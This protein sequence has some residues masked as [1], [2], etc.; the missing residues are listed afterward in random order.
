MN[1]KRLYR[2]LIGLL[3]A[4]SLVACV[5][6]EFPAPIIEDV[7]PNYE[8]VFPQ[9]QVNQI[10]LVIAPNDWEAMQTN[11]V[12]IFGEAG[13]GGPGGRGPGDGG[14][15][16]GGPG[17]GGPDGG[18]PG[19]GGPRA[20]GPP[21]CPP[22]GGPGGPGGPGG[23]PGGPGGGPDNFS[24]ENPMWVPATLKFEDNEWENVGVR[25]KGNSSLRSGWREGNAKMPLKLDFDEFEDEYPEID[26]QRF[27]GFK[28]FSLANGFADPSFLRDAMTYDILDEA[29]LTAAETA[30]YEVMLDYGEGLVRLGLYTFIEVIDDTAVERHFGSDQGNIYEGDGRGANLA[31]GAFEQ[32][33]TSFHKENN[34]NDADWSDVE[35]LYEVLHAAQRLEDPAA[36]RA[37]L[38]A[39]FNTEVFLE[40]LALSAAIQHWDGYGSIPHNFYLYNDSESGQLT[41]ISWDHNMAMFTDDGPVGF[42]GPGAP[43]GNDGPNGVV[44]HQVGVDRIRV[45]HWTS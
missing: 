23:G 32:I 2:I 33:S 16:G 30:F 8:V 37:N 19:R 43:P 39:I 21:P 34:R 45:L 11:M 13:A 18:D 27:Y 17:G 3:L 42:R 5:Q 10:T 1:Q 38:D 25:Y 41:W 24:S 12:E 29:G 14:P 35:A 40:W 28:Q 31:D 26:N 36:W 4:L 7:E 20:E 15:G 22:G 9:D 6:G 44:H